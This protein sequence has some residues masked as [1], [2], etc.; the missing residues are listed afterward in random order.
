MLGW[1][2]WE[3]Q[4]QIT[5]DLLRTKRVAVASCNGS[6]KCHGFDEDVILSDGSV[7][8]AGSL[9][10]RHFSILAYDHGKQVA[11]SAFAFDNGLQETVR[12]TTDSG[13]TIVRTLN[14]PLFAG[15]AFRYRGVKPKSLG[16]VEAQSLTVGNLVLVPSKLFTTASCPV[17][18][19]HVKLCAY[20]I[21]DGGLT[22]YTPHFTKSDGPQRAELIETIKRLG[23]KV[24]RDDGLTLAVSRT[25]K[26]H[27]VVT[28]LLRTWG[29]MGKLS[30]DKRFPEWVWRLPDSQM[31]LFLSR[32]FGCDGWAYSRIKNNRGCV[33]IGYASASEGLARDVLMA[34]LRLGVT[35]DLQAK[36][37]K[38]TYKGER[39]VRPSWTFSITRSDDIRAFIDNVGI[40]GKEGAVRRA[41]SVLSTRDLSRT[42]KWRSLN[43]PPGYRWEYIESIESAGKKPTVGISVPGPEAYVTTFVEHNSVLSSKLTAW[44]LATRKDSVVV[45]TS[46]TS[47]QLYNHLWRNIRQTAM[48]SKR[49]LGG[50]CQTKKWEIGPKW[51]ATGIATDDETN[52][53]G[54][55]TEGADGELLVII[56]EAS[57]CK[58]YVFDAIQGYLTSDKSYVLML[59]NPNSATGRFAEIFKRPI[60][61]YARHQISA[62]DVPIEVMSG[63]DEW[64]EHS[65]QIWGEGSIQWQVRVLGQFPTRGADLQL[66]PRWL[67]EDASARE[68][69]DK[70]RH[71]GVDVA[72]SGAD[73]N[74]AALMVDGVLSEFQHWQSADTMISAEHVARL[75]KEWRVDHGNIHVE[76]DGIG[77]AVVDRLREGGVMCDAV[78]SG[79]SQLDD[80]RDLTGDMHFAN[81][82]AEL[83]FVLRQG[84]LKGRFSIPRRFELFWKDLDTINMEPD[85]EKGIYKLEP[86]KRLRARTGS[87][88]DFADALIVSMSRQGAMPMIYWL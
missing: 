55:H 3:K 29:L 7:V 23:C 47:G 10:G 81:R 77:A 66:Y 84:L 62:F 41:Q 30:K 70:G 74:V 43:C 5:L 36:Q 2:P 1:S 35:G 87:S 46:A 72:G 32:L 28:A 88:P 44:F 52:F 6:G 54:F 48:T 16:W 39:R 53:Q 76:K 11:R 31:R 71:I 51:Y 22:S 8:T 13:R 9:L 15:E 26:E 37:S 4:R 73:N 12:I 33:Q 69:T 42:H 38:Y 50:E 60:D 18:D 78:Q 57:G 58:D 34:C 65:R 61:L 40:F 68:A 85:I 86:K 17:P 64:I 20:M 27:N 21:A 80:W 14:H 49:P 56:D 82:K 83:A 63:R 24:G 79:G 25:A 67:L 45:T 75:A 59:G 19:E